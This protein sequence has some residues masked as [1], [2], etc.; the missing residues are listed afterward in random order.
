MDL[1]TT[2]PMVDHVAQR[3]ARLLALIRRLGVDLSGFTRADKGATFAK[4]SWNCI[5][6]VHPNA[7]IEW[8][9]KRAE[10]VASPQP[11]FCPNCELLRG[12]LGIEAI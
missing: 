8:L 7:C 9:E 1:S 3:E 2:R 12:Y 5:R 6:C 11:H 10:G 4:A